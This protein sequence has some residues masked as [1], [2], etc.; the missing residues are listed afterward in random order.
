MVLRS[1]INPRMNPLGVNLPI[2][3]A[4]FHT[5]VHTHTLSPTEVYP[6]GKRW[7]I[8]LRAPHWDVRN[9]YLCLAATQDPSGEI[10][11]LTRGCSL[12]SQLIHI[13]S[14]AWATRAI[15]MHGSNYTHYWTRKGP[16]NLDFSF[17]IS[18]AIKQ[19]HFWEAALQ[20]ERWCGWCIIF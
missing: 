20:K 4:L 3:L 19:K 13:N 12:Q 8:T 10:I 18:A 17:I 5:A 2:S 15:W 1:I 9:N 7:L 16:R 14:R 11:I 6:E